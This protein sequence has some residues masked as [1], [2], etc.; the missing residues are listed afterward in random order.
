MIWRI[1]HTQLV[2]QASSSSYSQ[3]FISAHDINKENG[4][5]TRP[6]YTHTTKSSNRTSTVS[7]FTTL[8]YLPDGLTSTWLTLS[9][10]NPSCLQ[11]VS[12]LFLPQK[13]SRQTVPQVPLKSIST[14]PSVS[15]TPLTP[16][17]RTDPAARATGQEQSYYNHSSVRYR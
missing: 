13:A 12:P 17:R 6:G 9:I 4:L 3:F 5:W 15:F 16:N 14:L 10:L 7:F 11:T 1:A 2:R 8:I